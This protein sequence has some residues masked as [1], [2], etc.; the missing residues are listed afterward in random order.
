MMTKAEQRKMRHLEIMVDEQRAAISR[1]MEVYR[2]ISL[3]NIE[4][5][6]SI[7]HIEE[8]AQCGC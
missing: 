1:H 4:L 7:A 3:E 2:E 8:M 6:S 5:R